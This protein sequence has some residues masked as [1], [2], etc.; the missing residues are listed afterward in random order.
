MFYKQ[1]GLEM[2]ATK[3]PLISTPTNFG[4][5]VPNHTAS[6]ADMMHV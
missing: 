3:C 6:K 2:R 1:E 5:A 4:R